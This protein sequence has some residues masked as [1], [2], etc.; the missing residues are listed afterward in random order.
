M[1]K[2]VLEVMLNLEAIL[3]VNQEQEVALDAIS[4]IK[5]FKIYEYLFSCFCVNKMIKLL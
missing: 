3:E 2:I 1:Q 4:E 5:I